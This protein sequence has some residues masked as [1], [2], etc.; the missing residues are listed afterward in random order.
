MTFVL[1]GGF[2]VSYVDGFIDFFLSSFHLIFAPIS[3]SFREFTTG[4]CVRRPQRLGVGMNWG[5]EGAQRCGEGRSGVIFFS[6]SFLNQRSPFFLTFSSTL[7]SLF[8]FLNMLVLYHFEQE[9]NKASRRYHIKRW[10]LGVFF[11][12]IFFYLFIM[13]FLIPTFSAFLF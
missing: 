11:L 13:P 3:I 4:G 8:G 7:S 10:L 2:H 9:Y 12:S 6:F 5:S 1:I